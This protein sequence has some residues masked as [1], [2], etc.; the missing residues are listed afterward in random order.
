MK[1]RSIAAVLALCIAVVSMGYLYTTVT[2][3]PGDITDPLVTRRYVD[4]RIAQVTA[5]LEALRAQIS[6][7]GVAFPPPAEPGQPITLS[8]REMLFQDVM[9]F[10]EEVYGD[11]LRVAMH[12]GA[13]EVVPFEALFV[14]AGRILIAEAGVEFI[15]RSGNG[16]AI[17]G[18]DGMVNITAGVDV[19][20][21]E[22]IPHN[23]LML[24]PR[25]DGRG[26]SFVTD[27]WLMIKG[28]YNIVG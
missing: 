8:D 26:I 3:Q 2:A 5:E 1:K 19:S 15:L 12:G 21:G 10:F 20:N 7:G 13:G 14:P 25:S 22:T 4:D 11:M 6:G 24:V 18:P 27:S 23:N 17:S 9:I 28:G 16:I